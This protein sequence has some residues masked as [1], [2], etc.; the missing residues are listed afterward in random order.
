MLNREKIWQILRIL[1]RKKGAFYAQKVRIRAM[2][3]TQVTCFLAASVSTLQGIEA[4][5]NSE[6]E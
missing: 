3:V 2:Q 5:P 4:Q 6:E 1:V